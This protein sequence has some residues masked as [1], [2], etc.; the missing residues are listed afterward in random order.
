MAEKDPQGL[1]SASGQADE[2]LS[3][4]IYLLDTCIIIDALNRKRD[5]PEQLL[6]LLHAGHTLAC[7]P[8]NI[9]EVYA[10]MKPREATSTESFLSS[11]QYFTITPAV[12]RMAGQ[13]KSEFAQKGKTLNLGDVIIAAVSIHYGLT[14]ITDN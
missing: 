11:L 7:C 4:A 14:L 2:E 9:T 1:R 12:A 13:I 6:T 8:I 5:R 3:V 10:G